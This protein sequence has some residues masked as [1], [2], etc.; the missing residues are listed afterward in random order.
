MGCI[1][2]SLLL[3]SISS[4]HLLSK[5]LLAKHY[6][7]PLVEGA[8]KAMDTAHQLG[9]RVPRVKRIIRSGYNVWCIMERI[10]GATLENVW[11]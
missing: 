1:L 3:A 6:E 10:M 5:S 7:A 11:R 2:A 4:V 9:I 8:L